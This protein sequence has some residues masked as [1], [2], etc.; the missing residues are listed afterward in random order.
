MLS[1]MRLEAHKALVHTAAASNLGHMLNRLCLADGVALVNIVRSA[2]Q[3][4]ILRAIGSKHVLNSTT[5]DF[6]E[7]LVAAIS[8]TGATLA[9]DAVGGGPLAGQIL[10]AME[11]ALV[12]VSGPTVAR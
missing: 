11:A 10:A 1:T 6:H 7:R 4:S 9:F 3:V 2:E 5:P 8:E 12:A